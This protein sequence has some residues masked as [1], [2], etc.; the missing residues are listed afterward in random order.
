MPEIVHLRTTLRLT[1]LAH[2]EWALAVAPGDWAWDATAGNGHDTAFL[3]AKVG[4]VGQVWA[5][6]IQSAALTQ[7]RARLDRIPDSAPVEWRQASHADVG[8]AL[9]GEYAGRIAVV[10]FNLG[11]LP[12][13]ENPGLVTIPGETVLAIEAARQLLKPGGLLSVLAYR[14][15][16]GGPEEATSVAENLRSWTNGQAECWKGLGAPESAPALFLWRAPCPAQR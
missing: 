7:A 13:G 2:R 9:A 4:P 15:H 8:K 1:L 6:D 11:F 12:G 5:C 3:A 14:G 10:V 16:C